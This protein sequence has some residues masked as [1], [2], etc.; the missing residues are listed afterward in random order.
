[1]SDDIPVLLE[2]EEE[3]RVADGEVIIP[4]AIV[5]M[6]GVDAL[7][8]MLKRV[9]MAAYGTDK[10]VEQDAGKEVVLDMLGE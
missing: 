2:G 3:I 4:K 8:N 5:D 9:R 1:M 7:D 10:Q 6:F